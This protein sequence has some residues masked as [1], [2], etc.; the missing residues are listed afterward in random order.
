MYPVSKNI[1]KS[2]QVTPP[3]NKNRQNS[4][5][6]KNSKVNAKDVKY[7]NTRDVKKQSTP[8]RATVKKNSAAC[9]SEDSDMNESERN[10]QNKAL[11]N[12]KRG[13]LN[14]ADHY[15]DQDFIEQETLQKIDQILQTKNLTSYELKILAQTCLEKSESDNYSQ[16]SLYQEQGS[17][18]Q[19]GQSR[20]ISRENHNIHNLQK[21]ISF[22]KLETNQKR[23]AYFDKVGNGGLIG[24]QESRENEEYEEYQTSEKRNSNRRGKI[25]NKEDDMERY[26]YQNDRQQEDDQY[27]Q[28][29]DT[30]RLLS[31]IRNESENH[32]EELNRNMQTT[33]RDPYSTQRSS[34]T[35]QFV[36]GQQLEQSRQPQGNY[37]YQEKVYKAYSP[38]RIF[39]KSQVEK[40]A[41]KISNFEVEQK[42]KEINVVECQSNDYEDNLDYYDYQSYHSNNS[43]LT[44]NIEKKQFF[45]HQGMSQG[46]IDALFTSENSN[47]DIDSV[48]DRNFVFK[49]PKN[50]NRAGW[51]GQNKQVASQ[52]ND[53]VDYSSSYT[54]TNLRQYDENGDFNKIGGRRGRNQDIRDNKMKNSMMKPK[55]K[56]ENQTR[57]FSMVE[58]AQEHSYSNTPQSSRF[59]GGSLMKMRPGTPSYESQ[60]SK[61]DI[62]AYSQRN[63]GEGYRL[64]RS[65]G[66]MIYF[67]GSQQKQSQDLQFKNNVNNINN[68]KVTKIEREGGPIFQDMTSQL[69]NRR[70][71]CQSRGFQNTNNNQRSRYAMNSAEEYQIGYPMNNQLKNSQKFILNQQ[72]KYKEDS[73]QNIQI[74]PYHNGV[75]KKVEAATPHQNQRVRQYNNSSKFQSRE[76]SL[77][78]QKN[79]R[80]TMNN[81]EY[82]LGHPR[83]R[84]RTQPPNP[85]AYQKS[86]ENQWKNQNTK[87]N[88]ENTYYQRG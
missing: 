52:F 53:E 37:Q 20:N 23:R 6:N 11:N 42:K 62:S 22:R 61:V 69:K 44:S 27:Y 25:P 2:N 17:N 57:N 74:H 1:P 72:K 83:S 51:S 34:D 30:H 60:F 29:E 67:E 82:S 65:Q 55:I 10:H 88:K 19:T 63:I 54:P 73:S 48:N 12:P 45:K 8:S 33:S 4:L 15:Y 58:P 13:L 70:Q 85:Y 80:P 39:T 21:E 66:K 43:N 79:R 47:L 59:R 16:T 77:R 78:Q 68:E 36:Q 18:S 5:T 26:Q 32:Q 31:G 84:Q 86:Y 14:Y 50:L 56:P 24:V 9:Q 64:G 35:T 28:Q 75:Y 76:N 40:E 41:Q 3:S 81:R 7:K 38:V 49:D 46:K 71:K 87:T